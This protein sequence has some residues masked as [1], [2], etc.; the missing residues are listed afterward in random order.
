MKLFN[1]LTNKIDLNFKSENLKKYCGNKFQ[2]IEFNLLAE[3]DL[4][5]FGWYQLRHVYFKLSFIKTVHHTSPFRLRSYVIRRQRGRRRW[6]RLS[7]WTSGRRLRGSSLV[8]AHSHRL[9]LI[10]ADEVG[11]IQLR[12]CA[13]HIKSRSVVS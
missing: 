2:Y 9:H 1:G 6:R 5:K 11:K 10:R 7:L 3:N 12:F 8:I 4:S 13:T